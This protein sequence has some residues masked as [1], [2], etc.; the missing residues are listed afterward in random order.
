MHF[1]PIN[2]NKKKHNNLSSILIIVNGSYITIR[3]EQKTLENFERGERWMKMKQ[4]CDG[5]QSSQIIL[6]TKQ[7]SGNNKT[8]W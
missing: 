4:H 7:S 2:H 1:A 6:H 3:V 5:P 8:D